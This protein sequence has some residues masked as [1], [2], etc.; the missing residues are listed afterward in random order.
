MYDVVILGGGPGGY[1]AAERTAEA[2]LRTV[3]IEEHYLGGTCLNVGCIPTKTLLNSAKTVAHINQSARIGV[4][5]HA[6]FDLPAAMKWKT[7]VISGLRKG[8][9][10]TLKK[11][12]VEVVE[13]RGRLVA[14]NAVQVGSARYEGRYLILASGSSPAR[15]PVPGIDSDGVV[16]SSGL[17]EIST[18]PKAVTVVGGG[19]IGMEFASFFALLGVPVTVVEMMDEIIP[20]MEPELAALLRKS[21]TGVSYRLGERVKRIEAGALICERDGREERVESEL[22]LIS[23]GR[24]P[25]VSGLGFEENGLDVDRDG[26][27]VNDYLET[28]LPG[29]FAVGDVTGRS[30]LAHSAYRMADVAASRILEREGHGRAQRMRYEAV[31]WVVFTQPEVAGCG[32]TAAEA[33]RAGL[34]VKT[35]SISLKVSGRYVAEHPGENGTARVIADEQS[36]RILGVQ[37]LGSGVSELIFGA[38][39]MIENELRIKDVREVIFPHPTVSEVYRDVMWDME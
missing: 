17:L 37:M 35:G 27:R 38:A 6:S 1:R 30:L 12:G 31:P 14:R 25:N 24:R 36:G 29:V 11:S 13:G 26:I 16:D 10:A 20:F 39:L 15:P 22:I 28:N 33:R 9:A 5:A 18:M 3:L 2:G 8:I 34:T 4:R 21:I 7:Q 23:T 32:M 19:Y